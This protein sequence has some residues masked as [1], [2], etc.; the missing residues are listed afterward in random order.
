MLTVPAGIWHRTRPAGARSVNLTFE[1]ANAAA[2]FGDEAGE[3]E[4]D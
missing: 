1:R 3:R 4:P 2:V